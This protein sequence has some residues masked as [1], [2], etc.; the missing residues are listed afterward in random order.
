MWTFGAVN[1]RSFAVLLSFLL[2]AFPALGER[3]E[4]AIQPEPVW[5]EPAWDGPQFVRADRKGNVFLFRG[6]RLEVY[7][8]TRKGSLGDPLRLE[9]TAE[10]SRMVQDAVLSPDGGRWL[11]YADLGVRLFEDGKEKPVPP[12]SWRPWSIAF[13]RDTPL[14]AVVPVPIGD[15]PLDLERLAAVPWFLSL[16]NGR[17]ATFVEHRR[18][19]GSELLKDE[20]TMNDFVADYAVFTVGDREGKLWVARQ[21]S[22]KVERWSPGGRPLLEI[23]VQGGK[24]VHRKETPANPEAA[25]A[26]KRDK[27]Q[28][29]ETR[30]NAFTARAAI[31]DLVEGRDHR[32]Y[33]LVNTSDDGALALDRYDPVLSVLERTPLSLEKGGRFTMAAGKEG[34]YLAAW[35]GRDGRWRIPWEALDAAEWMEVEG[36]EIK[37]GT[38]SSE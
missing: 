37:G 36:A 4:K 2:V 3:A 35:N 10:A 7:P 5:G 8:V 16:D 11:V 29:R 12:L 15:P 17:W 19:P 9:T 13:L 32:L 30:F 23:A 31:R 6:S 26:V 22:Y 38:A 14:V 33:L 21:Y 28:G 18:L 20:R 24:V 25:A 27:T 34:L 1:M